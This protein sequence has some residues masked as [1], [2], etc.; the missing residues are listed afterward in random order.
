MLDDAEAAGLR[1][2][3]VLIARSFSL[4][5]IYQTRPA[6]RQGTM[7]TSLFRRVNRHVTPRPGHDDCHAAER[8]MRAS[9]KRRQYLLWRRDAARPSCFV[10]KMAAHYVLSAAKTCRIGELISDEIKRHAESNDRHFDAP[11]S[12]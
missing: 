1:H 4:K 9:T 12:C 2:R 7:V 10:A 8:E 11:V 5:A 6:W 3:V